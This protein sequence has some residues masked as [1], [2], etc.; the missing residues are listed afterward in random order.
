[1]TAKHLFL[2]FLL[3]CLWFLA[4]YCHLAEEEKWSK[5][6]SLGRSSM[7]LPDFP[8][9]S[10]VALNKKSKKSIRKEIETKKSSEKKA[11]V[12]KS[13]SASTCAATG[14]FCQ[15]QTIS[16]CDK[17]DTCH[18]RFFGSVCFCRPFMRKC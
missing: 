9:V 15:P 3:A 7:N 18:C 17:C 11:V 10:I 14:A 6:R 12:K 16:C 13:S 5:D 8:S 2:P 4:A 1:M